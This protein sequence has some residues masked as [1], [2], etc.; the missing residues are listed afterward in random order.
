MK[1]GVLVLGLALSALAVPVSAHHSWTADMALSRLVSFAATRQLELRVEI[2]NLFNN[3]NW[4]I[5]V[6]NFDAGTF[7]RITSSAGDPRI[8][9]FG[10]KYGF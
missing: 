8:M 7:G 2:F 1:F 9:Q 5:P 10:I 6:T 4:G 3:F